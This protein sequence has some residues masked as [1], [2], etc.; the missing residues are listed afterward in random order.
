M[1]KRQLF[2]ELE[3][4]EIEKL[5][6]LKGKEVNEAKKILAF[7][8][9]KISRGIKSANE[10]KEIADNISIPVVASGGVGSLQHLVDGVKMGN[11]SGVLAASIFHYG[12]FSIQEAKKFMKKSGVE[13]RL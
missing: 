7:E 8:V 1:Y 13:V 10:A 11:A 4:Y 5:S 3:L 9:T 6:K 2:T 12:K